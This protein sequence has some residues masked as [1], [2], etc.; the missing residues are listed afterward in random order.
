VLSAWHE[1]DA[2]VVNTLI[3]TLGRLRETAGSAVKWLPSL[4]RFVGQRSGF[5][6][7]FQDD[8]GAA[9]DIGQPWRRVMAS[10][11]LVLAA[12][13]LGG[14]VVWAPSASGLTGPPLGPG[15]PLPTCRPAR[16]IACGHVTTLTGSARVLAQALE[17]RGLGVLT[18]AQLAGRKKARKLDTALMHGLAS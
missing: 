18:P 7:G 16:T 9:L 13:L 10:K 2:Q 17:R 12:V 8:P 11:P 14:C 4:L 1:Q 5:V 15:P 3:Y 6:A